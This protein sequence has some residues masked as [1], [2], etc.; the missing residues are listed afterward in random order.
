M[1]LQTGGISM[2]EAITHMQNSNSD[3]FLH[4]SESKFQILQVKL[5]N[6]GILKLIRTYFNLCAT[7]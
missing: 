5:Y 6:G 7:F 1:S 3:L 4:L 2:L